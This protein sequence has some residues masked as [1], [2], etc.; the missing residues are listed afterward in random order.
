MVIDA[1]PAGQGRKQFLSTRLDEAGLAPTT[2]AENIALAA[3]A[4]GKAVWLGLETPASHLEE[5]VIRPD[6][7]KTVLA[8][9][10]ELRKKNQDIAS[11]Y[12][13]TGSFGPYTPRE[14]ALIEKTLSLDKNQPFAEQMRP[15]T[16]HPD[17]NLR[18]S[19]VTT[20]LSA[21]AEVDHQHRLS[22]EETGLNIS[23][24]VITG[25]LN[26]A[27]DHQQQSLQFAYCSFNE[28]ITLTSAHL[29]ELTLEGCHCPG[30]NAAYARIDGPT[31]LINGFYAT[32]PIQFE[33]AVLNG[34]FNGTGAILSPKDHDAPTLSLR[35]ATLK[36][37]LSFGD[38]FSAEGQL[39]FS[40]L[41]CEQDIKCNHAILTIFPENQYVPAMLVERATI[42]GNLELGGNFS[43]IGSIL[44][45]GTTINGALN[46]E[47]GSFQ[48]PFPESDQPAMILEDCAINHHMEMRYAN[49]LGAMKMKHI[50]LNGDLDLSNIACSAKQRKGKTT[51]LSMDDI[52]IPGSL[53]LKES[54]IRG[55]ILLENLKIGQSLHLEGAGLENISVSQMGNAFTLS[56]VTINGNA[57]FAGGLDAK[58]HI[59][60]N[61]V[62]IDGNLNMAGSRFEGDVQLDNTTI[63]GT[64]SFD[65][66]AE[67][68][69]TFDGAIAIV[70]SHARILADHKGSWPDDLVLT[71]FTYDHFGPGVNVNAI[72]RMKWLN[73]QPAYTPSS[74]RQ[75]I[76]TLTHDGHAVEAHKVRQQKAKRD[77]WHAYNNNIHYSNKFGVPP[78]PF[79]V[80]MRT[81]FYWPLTALIWLIYGGLW[82]YG[83]SAAR[84]LVIT[85]IIICGGA[86]F[87]HKAE[88]QGLLMP[89]APQLLSGQ[90]K[91]QCSTGGPLNWTGC[92][93][94]PLPRFSPLFYST[95]ASLPFINLEQ[96]AHWRPAEK[97]LKLDLPLP[98]CLQWDKACL[99][100]KWITVHLKQQSLLHFKRAQT[101]FGWLLLAG[102]LLIALRTF[103][104]KRQV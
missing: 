34:P 8:S 4:S 54:A 16:T 93:Q 9:I 80:N 56:G 40:H 64:L 76:R 58:G 28:T 98:G 39:D 88:Q 72:E 83:L 51:A 12:E 15:P 13:W 73:L 19:F 90:W 68:I 3:A 21:L 25:P 45:K 2:S 101:L 79:M 11:I 5:T 33:H 92:E 63:E 1:S 102:L 35:H 71:N 97:S 22:P 87:Y 55:K 32:G 89:A 100:P 82:S 27:G 10:L 85:L 94:L 69:S 41:T 47:G 17:N 78:S 6:F 81:L 14:M 86:F 67:A 24:A 59:S 52:I 65:N 95:D 103:L 60:F 30:I 84:L 36:S 37:G 7:A 74:W 57:N 26:L 104:P 29:N 99:T 44:I 62:R 43:A 91:Q 53:N 23:G 46:M 31:N 48:N 18:A 50:R 38:N 70:N 96:T 66:P 75:L 42:G 20:L 77:Y 49:I 61:T